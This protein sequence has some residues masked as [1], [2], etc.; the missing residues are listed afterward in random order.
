V[1]NVLER[2]VIIGHSRSNIH[3]HVASDVPPNHQQHQAHFTTVQY[4]VG[5]TNSAANFAANWSTICNAQRTAQRTAV[6]H[7]NNAAHWSTKF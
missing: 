1:E 3:S 2:S 4:A 7:A 6:N 5:A